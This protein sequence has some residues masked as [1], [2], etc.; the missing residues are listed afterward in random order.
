MVKKKRLAEAGENGTDTLSEQQHRTKTLFW[1]WGLLCILV[2]I[3]LCFGFLNFV[4]FQ[5]HRNQAADLEKKFEGAFDKFKIEMDEK[6]KAQELLLQKFAKLES[7]V[8]SN[9]EQ[10]Q[11]AVKS[12]KRSLR[13]EMERYVTLQKFQRQLLNVTQ[14]AERAS[15][16]AKRADTESSQKYQKLKHNVDTK[17]KNLVKK[18]ERDYATAYNFKLFLTRHG[19]V[20][21]TDLVQR[22]GDYVSKSML[23]RET[24]HLRKILETKLTL[25]DFENR[26]QTT[27]QKTHTD[28]E[29]MK[30]KLQRF[31]RD[32]QRIA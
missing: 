7:A 25:Q 20:F 29:L 4:K 5:K 30:A 9:H 24:E 31:N 19:V 3:S 10:T 21:H 2:V 22:F 28:I 15:M 16:R 13:G 18:L 32:L 1:C 12:T 23:S 27:S 14:I 26:Q 11:R 17:I 6:L 8:K